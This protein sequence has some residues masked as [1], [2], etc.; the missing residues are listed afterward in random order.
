[1]NEA[2][3]MIRHGW[4]ELPRKFPGVQLDEFIIMPN[5]FH[6]II[7]ISE[8]DSNNT[9]IRRTRAGVSLPEIVQW[10][11]TMTTNAY[12]RGVRDKKWS[13]FLSRLWQR[14]YYERIIRDETELSRFRE[15]I[16]TNPARWGDDEDN[17]ARLG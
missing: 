12:I 7:I 16:V 5:H 3:M 11:K 17:V 14:N 4:L 2:G 8:P 6:G 15:Y 9:P 1:M 10:F 13:P